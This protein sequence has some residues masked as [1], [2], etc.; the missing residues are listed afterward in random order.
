M[1]RGR[2]SLSGV[3]KKVNVLKNLKTQHD[4]RAWIDNLSPA[5]I[6]LLCSCIKRVRKKP[7]NFLTRKTRATLAKRGKILRAIETARGI[8]SKRKNLHKL[9]QR[10]SGAIISEYSIIKIFFL[11]KSLCLNIY[12]IIL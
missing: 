9:F 10:G 8:S 4:R 1:V 3:K 6:K 2:V 12:Q 11:P 5:E 7:K